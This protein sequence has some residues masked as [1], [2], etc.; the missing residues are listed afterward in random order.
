MEKK[1]NLCGHIEK[2]SYSNKIELSVRI[3]IHI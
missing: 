3:I 1:L 2:Y